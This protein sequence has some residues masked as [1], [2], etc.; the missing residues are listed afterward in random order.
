MTDV[1]A[2]LQ[3]HPVELAAPADPRRLKAS[4]VVPTYNRAHVLSTCLRA[5]A[6]QTLE[7][8]LHEIIVVDDGSKDDTAKVCRA[9]ADTL[10]HLRVHR[11]E[12]RG[13]AAARNAGIRLAAGDLVVFT[14]DD[15]VPPPDWLARIVAAFDG[16][17]GLGALGGVMITPPDQWIPLTH[18]SDLTAPGS[19]DYSRFI[20]T[21]NAVYR[22]DVL[23]RVGGFDETF[24]H[25]SV[26]D[27]ELYLRVRRIAR[28]AI[29]PHLFVWHPPRSMSVGEA[30]RGYIRFYRGYEALEKAYPEEFHDLYGGSAAAPVLKGR[31]WRARA[32]LYAPGMVR[33]PWRGV[34][35]LVYLALSRAIVAALALATRMRRD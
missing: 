2:R 4:V 19:A 8:E 3:M 10:P 24:R 9:W 17:A 28:T 11:Q 12:N 1:A 7:Q 30:L 5:L 33:F 14:D 22:R 31:S 13:P 20:G 25:V 18:H 27:A 26:E 6:G 29:D 21:N 35:F 32:R 16:D 23:R 15:C 34:Q